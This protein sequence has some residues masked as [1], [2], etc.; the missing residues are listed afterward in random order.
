MTAPSETQAQPE[1][2]HF[3]GFAGMNWKKTDAVYK[4]LKPPH[5]QIRKID[6]VNDLKRQ[7]KR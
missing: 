6:P 3:T 5:R 4:N 2:L 1:R 7:S